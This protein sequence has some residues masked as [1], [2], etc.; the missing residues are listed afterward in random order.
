MSWNAIAIGLCLKGTLLLGVAFILNAALRRAPAATR[1]LLWTAVLAALLCL[2]ALSILLPGWPV[3]WL[4]ALSGGAFR[5]QASGIS[6]RGASAPAPAATAASTSV[7]GVSP[8]KRSAGSP[9][10]SLLLIWAAGAS[11]VLAR[12]MA[13]VAVTHGLGSRRAQP[14]E[15]EAW[16]GMLASLS[17]RLGI[18]R[19]VRLL[20][21]ERASI[22]FTWGLLRPA[23]LLPA[24]AG[25]WTAERREVV[26][27]HELAHVK[28]GDCWTQL[29]A[30][31]TCV[32]YWFHP[33]V[34]LATR[35]MI[36]E[37]ERA[38]DD[39]VLRLGTRPSD[40]A[41]LLLELARSLRPAPL[42]AWATTAM[43]RRS[44]L[45]SRLASILDGNR[46]RGVLA[47]PLAAGVLMM[48]ALVVI[49]L[50]AMRPQS[51]T[52]GAQASAKTF[53]RMV[54]EAKASIQETERTLGPD[55]PE[56]ADKLLQLAELYR[57]HRKSPEAAPLTRRALIIQEKALGPL[58]PGLA[59]ALYDLGLDAH[60]RGDLDEAA[61]FYT[62]TL[63]LRMGTLG[64]SH[65]DTAIVL[66]NLALIKE[67]QKDLPAAEQF[68]ERAITIRES[69]QLAIT[70]EHYARLLRKLERL[71][72]AES[73]QA[74]A[75]E[76]RTGQ[77]RQTWGVGDHSEAGAFRSGNGVT[78]P[79]L[80]YKI[81]PKYSE[82]A[83]LIRLQGTVVLSIHVSP[84]GTPQK[85]HLKRGLGFGLDEEAFAAVSQ[86]RFQPGT[87]EGQPVPVVATIEV[88]F[89]LW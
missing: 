34:W 17:A 35:Q 78:A 43:L 84:E 55:H 54:E 5:V 75:N 88:N 86:W 72:E 30:R 61:E 15:S 51:E 46:A 29:A 56:L 23:I 85:F 82:Q 77:L 33:L 45:E 41:R 49:P 59:R 76:I 71:P 8:T 69:P 27:L 38:A 39:L 9:S 32:L 26:L 65:P 18:S 42:S 1:H 58:H 44:E 19:P 67:W 11:L 6:G 66:N 80:A 79:R 53:E 7:G 36:R 14:I 21:G 16:D 13:G 63:D 20:Q 47:T 57:G 22:P 52:P 73:A 48:S 3:S 2:P 62:R 25:N 64:A 83:R 12:L 89:R 70:L 4:N 10:W 31:L 68:Y 60:R 50:A 81:E 87:R 37:R 74:R 40:Y 24:E 28:R